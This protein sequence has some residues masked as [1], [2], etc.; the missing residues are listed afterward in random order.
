M[1]ICVVF[2]SQETLLS[3]CN[4]IDGAVSQCGFFRWRSLHLLAV[5]ALKSDSAQVLV[6]KGLI[7]WALT[8]KLITPS[9]FHYKIIKE[10]CL[11]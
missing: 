1:C 11:F 9:Y 2:A 5:M 10:K 4:L 3:L 8:Y 7:W 6:G